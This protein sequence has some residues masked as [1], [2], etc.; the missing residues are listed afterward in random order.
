MQHTEQV[1]HQ[2]PILSTTEYCPE[3]G[4]DLDEVPPRNRYKGWPICSVCDC[5][6][7]V[8]REEQRIK[9]VRL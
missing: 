4:V 1:L 7:R 2:T 3:C 6:I 9:E 8:V 5:D